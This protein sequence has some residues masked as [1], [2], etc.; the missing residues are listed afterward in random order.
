M[1]KKFKVTGMMCTACSAHV[2]NA[3]RGLSGVKNAEVSLLLSSMTVE[4][5]E[6][7]LDAGAIVDAVVRVGYHAEEYKEGE[8]VSLPEERA[9]IKPL[10][11]SIPLSLLLMYLEMGHHMFHLPGFLKPTVHPSLWLGVQF[12]LALVICVINYRYFVGGFKSLVSRMPNMDSLIALGSG[13]AMLYGTGLFICSLVGYGDVALYTRATFSGAGMILTLVTLGKTLEG[14][15]K[16]K[17]SS[18]IRAL[19]SLVPDEVLV[20]REEKEVK[21]PLRELTMT[22]TII[23]RTGD[24][25]PADATLISGEISVDASALTGESLPVD[26]KSGATLICGTVVVDGYGEAVP[27]ALGDDTSLSQT[28]R[29]VSEASASKAPIARMADRVSAIFVPAVLLIASVTFILWWIFGDFG[30]AINHAISVLV[31]SCPCALG[32]ATPTAIMCAMGKGAT[33]GILIKDAT[34]LEA[35]GRCNAVA[36][37]KTGTLTKGEMQ[38][39][40]VM[41]CGE[42]E[43]SELFALTSAIEGTSS[44]PI[45]KAIVRYIGDV[46]TRDVGKISVLAGKGIFAKGEC[47]SFAIGNGALM[48]ECDIETD[49]AQEFTQVAERR[50]ASVIYVANLDGLLGAFAVADTAREESATVIQTLGHMHIKSVMVTGDSAPSAK[51]IGEVVGVSEIYA[52]LTPEGKGEKIGACKADGSIV[53]MVG[54]GINDALPLVCADIGIAMG[55]GTDVAMESCDVVLR[56]SGLMM[57]P[58]LFA[59]GR[60]TLRKIRQNLFWALIYNSIC[61]PIAAGALS[62]LGVTLEPMMASL[63]MACSSLCV[64][65]NALLINRFQPKGVNK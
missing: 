3:V 55:N 59:L 61:I 12:L 28:V 32:L 33:L 57:V 45:A 17:T 5:D 1:K 58:T 65:C 10:L 47:G 4:Y 30:D 54:D 43:E 26:Y 37:D 22:D 63:A 19:G 56:S 16:D 44:H 49:E 60:L 13:A 62:F 64:V 53:A 36:F 39:V 15:A 50:G 27:T 18:A 35:V 14:R 42:T 6:G 46:P 38:V 34:T 41:V 7:A 25:I 48:E 11:F 40:D 24:R 9:N 29:M 8:K 23:L 51:A 52:S 21:I 31:I 2:E 20:L